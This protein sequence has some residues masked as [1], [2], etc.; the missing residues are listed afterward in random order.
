MPDPHPALVGA[1]P[2]IDTDQLT[3]DPARLVEA[4]RDGH[5]RGP[6]AVDRSLLTEPSR[7][8]ADNSF[9][10]WPAWQPGVALGAKLVTVFPGNAAADHG[11]TVRSVFVLFD[12]LDGRPLAVVTGGAFTRHK[13]A[14]DSALGANY[15]A[16]SDAAHLVV[17]GAGA[18][19]QTHILYMLN[20]ICSIR[21]VTI[22]NRSRRRADD[23]A[24]ALRQDGIHATTTDDRP[25]AVSAADIVCC[26]TASTT[27]V[28]QGAWLRP[29]THVDLVGGFTPAMRECDD[30]AILRARLFV[31]HRALVLAHNGDIRD[32]LGRGVIT[33]ADVVGD[34]Y[35]LCRSDR[36]G[37]LTSREITLFKNGGG[38]HLDLMTA[39]ALYAWT[40]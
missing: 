33:E 29:G 19:A 17:L 31:D 28:L 27:P 13:T 22:W 2:V 3:I 6:G 37:R 9:L 34:L 24:A 11:P 26:L 38:G 23:L 4:L 20:C 14:A 10:V 35:D 40:R 36:P 25:G 1:L 15:L 32:P 30:A 5:R 39:R 21:Q 8:G 12:G 16:R 7:S 18:Q